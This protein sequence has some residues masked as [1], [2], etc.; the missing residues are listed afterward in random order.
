M[1]EAYAFTLCKVAEF[2]KFAAKRIVGKDD[3]SRVSFPYNHVGQWFLAAKTASSHAGMAALLRQL[4]DRQD[5]MLVPGAIRPGLDLG[6]P[7][8]RRWADPDPRKNTLVAAER[9]WLAIDVDGYGVPAP[10]GLAEHLAD[11]AR[12]IRDDALGDEFCDAACVVAATSSTG[13]EGEETA[14]L[15]L[16]FL[17]DREHPLAVL[18]RWARGAQVVGFQSTQR[19]CGLVSRSIRRD[20]GSRGRS[21]G[22]DPVPVRLR[23][24]RAAGQCRTAGARCCSPRGPAR[25]HRHQGARCGGELWR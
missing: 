5:L 3:G 17:L 24:L 14:K 4:A 13:L 18:E 1:P 20:R 22:R 25:A 2:D 8:L 11:A 16:F 23:A 21:P 10:W 9:A 6:R 7:Q 19:S 15:R 12:A